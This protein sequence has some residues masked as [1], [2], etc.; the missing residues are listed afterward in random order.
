[1]KKVLFFIVYIFIIRAFSPVYVGSR[2]KKRKEERQKERNKD[3]KKQT[4]KEIT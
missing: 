3:T 4:K 2:K 1:M